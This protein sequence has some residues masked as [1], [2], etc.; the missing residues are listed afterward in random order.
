LARTTSGIGDG[1]TPLAFF[2]AAVATTGVNVTTAA[3]TR[4]HLA[5]DANMFRSQ[6]LTYIEVGHLKRT[7]SLW[8][9]MTAT[10]TKSENK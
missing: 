10:A 5:R 2:L 6:H 9:Q 7:E 8:Q 4:L 3:I 1:K